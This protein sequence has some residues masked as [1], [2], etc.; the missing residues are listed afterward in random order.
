MKVSV[1]RGYYRFVPFAHLIRADSI[2]IIK[3]R[4]D[5]LVSIS[6]LGCFIDNKFAIEK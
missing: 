6:R 3:V 1:W 4:I 5:R 2:A